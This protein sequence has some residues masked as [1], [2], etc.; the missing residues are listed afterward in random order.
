MFIPPRHHA[1]AVL[2]KNKREF[3]VT[4]GTSTKLKLYPG[5][6]FST[7]FHEQLTR[8]IS[9]VVSGRKPELQA[10]L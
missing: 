5:A 7:I 10:V 3:G 8:F 1:C 6:S 4:M 9:V 2:T